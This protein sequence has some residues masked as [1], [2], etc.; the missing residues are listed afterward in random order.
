M[1]KKTSLSTTLA[2]A[3]MLATTLAQAQTLKFKR[4]NGTRKNGDSRNTKIHQ[5]PVVLAVRTKLP[6]VTGPDKTYY[7][8]VRLRGRWI[9]KGADGTTTRLNFS[10]SLVKMVKTNEWG[11]TL[12]NETFAWRAVKSSRTSRNFKFQLRYADGSFD[13][14]RCRFNRDYSKAKMVTQDDEVLILI[15][16]GRPIDDF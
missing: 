8:N 16:L 12:R 3:I 2:A 5:S 4:E 10:D 1:L 15:R 9:I 7:R 14:Y 13:N 6:R 11:E